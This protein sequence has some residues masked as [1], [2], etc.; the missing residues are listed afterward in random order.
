MVKN[1]FFFL[2]ASH[3]SPSPLSGK[4]QDK[5][6]F[7]HSPPWEPVWELSLFLCVLLSLTTSTG[8]RCSNSPY[9]AWS[10]MKG[11]DSCSR[12][13][14]GIG[15]TTPGHTSRSSTGKEPWLMV[16][17]LFPVL[18]EK[19]DW[20]DKYLRPF[21][22]H[23]PFRSMPEQDLFLKQL[24]APHLWA[25]CQHTP[26]HSHTPMLPY[27]QLFFLNE[28]SPDGINSSRSADG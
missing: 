20:E 3:T 16:C 11:G 27:P 7:F 2:V 17:H 23:H 18:L 10:N 19:D 6:K 4:E 25:V 28:N 14:R 13:L 15:R 26:V 1:S 9:V 21:G 5:N 12:G 24:T 22:G 8:P